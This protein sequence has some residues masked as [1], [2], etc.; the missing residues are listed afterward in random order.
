VKSHQPGGM[1]ITEAGIHWSA[2]AQACGTAKSVRE[3]S[4]SLL[5][6][7]IKSQNSKTVSAR[8]ATEIFRLDLGASLLYGFEKPIFR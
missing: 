2:D 7:E 4:G 6:T 8:T 3:N 5:L 1:I